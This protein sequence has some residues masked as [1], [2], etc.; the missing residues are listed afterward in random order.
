LPVG[1]TSELAVLAALAATALEERP[2]DGL[3]VRM[4]F[5]SWFKWHP[6]KRDAE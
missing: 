4:S 6:A 3:A 2:L 5:Q 1:K